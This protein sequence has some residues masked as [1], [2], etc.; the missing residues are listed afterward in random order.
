MEGGK[1]ED[2]AQPSVSTGEADSLDNISLQQSPLS[3]RCL[4]GMEETMHNDINQATTHSVCG[5]P[6][7][8]ARRRSILFVNWRSSAASDSVDSCHQFTE[9]RRAGT[10]AITK[11]NQPGLE[12]QQA[13]TRPQ[14][15]GEACESIGLRW[16]LTNRL[17]ADRKLALTCAKFD[18]A[19]SASSL[20]QLLK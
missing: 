7:D 6:L 20:R 2:G 17:S 5:T 10:I 14:Q 3:F 18:A 13:H 16:P 9:A 11:R 12:P 15:A 8:N 19:T 1:R 4:C